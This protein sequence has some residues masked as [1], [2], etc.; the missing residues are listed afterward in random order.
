VLGLRTWTAELFLPLYAFTELIGTTLYLLFRFGPRIVQ[1]VK[2]RHKSLYPTD[3]RAA[4]D[5]A[6]SLD[7]IMSRFKG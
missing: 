6:Y 2:R 3:N 1:G 5:Q 4:N 7:K